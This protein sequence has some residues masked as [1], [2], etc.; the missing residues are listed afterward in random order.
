MTGFGWQVAYRAGRR[1]TDMNG[2]FQRVTLG[3]S[4]H[5]PDIRERTR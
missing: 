2:A 4:I 3:L 1:G 5:A